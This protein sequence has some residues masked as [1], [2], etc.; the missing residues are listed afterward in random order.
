MNH[1]KNA[2]LP[3]NSLLAREAKNYRYSD[4]FSVQ[5]RRQDIEAWELICALANSAPPWVTVLS[6]LR[7]KIVGVLG[8][9]T[10]AGDPTL[11]VPP[12]HIGQQVGYFRVMQ[13]TDHEV[14][15]G[16]DDN[17]LNFRT[18]LHL[19]PHGTHSVLSVS[20]LVKTKNTV[21]AVYFSIVKPFHRLL[22]SIMVCKMGQLLDG[23][24][25]PTHYYSD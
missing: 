19:N 11:I 15:L 17:H 24:K 13:L 3:E 21:G 18:S 5:L 1:N 7:D 23:R 12:Y 25:L 8:L 20:T 22:V 14:I 2:D 10:G 9:K 6:K 16:D 4:C